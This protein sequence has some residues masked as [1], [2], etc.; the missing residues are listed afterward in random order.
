MI[1]VIED[2][3]GHVK[4]GVT[5]RLAAR[6]ANLQTGDASRHKLRV[7]VALGSSTLERALEAD[8]RRAFAGW[9]TAGGTEWVADVPVVRAWVR[10]LAAGRRKLKP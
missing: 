5:G 4:V 10:A 9:A 1:Y 7:A 3:R 8:F 6:L 2:G